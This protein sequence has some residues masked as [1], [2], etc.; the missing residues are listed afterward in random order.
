LPP[1][2]RTPRAL[3]AGDAD[4]GVAVAD[5]DVVPPIRIPAIAAGAA[6]RLHQI[7][8]R[9]SGQNVLAASANAQPTSRED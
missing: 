8:S 1:H 6:S 2:D 3:P 4:P 7:P 5:V 9:K